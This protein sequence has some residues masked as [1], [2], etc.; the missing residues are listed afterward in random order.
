MD[1]LPRLA[2]RQVQLGV[3]IPETEP[4]DGGVLLLAHAKLIATHTYLS[5]MQQQCSENC[6]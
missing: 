6:G 2:N 1:S 3:L 4:L 5:S